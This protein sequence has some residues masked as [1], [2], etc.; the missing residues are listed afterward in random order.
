[1]INCCFRVFDLLLSQ[2][3]CIGDK[4]RRD[5][6]V[7]ATPSLWGRVGVGLLVALLCGCITKYNPTGID[8]IAD[9][10]VVDGVITDDETIITL[11]HSVNLTEAQSVSTYYIDHAMVYVVCDDGTQWEAEPQWEGAKERNGRYLIKNGMLNTGRKYSL[12]IGIGEFDYISDYSYPI[13]TPE[14][15][16][17]FW[18]KTGRGQPVM[19]HVATQ[20][21][22]GN[23]MYCRW[24]YKEDWEI[25]SEIPLIGYPYFCWNTGN[26][27]EMLLGSSEKTVFGRITDVVAEIL[28]SNRKLAVMYRI[29]VRQN[30]IS[31]RG[32]DYYENI[33]INAKQIGS[34]FAPI[35][36]ELRGNITCTTDP[37]RPVI[38]YVDVSSTTQSRMYIPRSANV[39]ERRFSTD[40]EPFVLETKPDDDT[41]AVEFEGGYLW[42]DCVDCTRFG[43]EQKPDD[44][45]DND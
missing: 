25:N 34:I 31:K 38:G 40:C 29:D 2:I 30:A 26:S 22:D 13:I 23:A 7:P 11:S 32:Y 37:G 27:R 4:S 18:M 43:T 33:R 21:T 5:F 12:R 24:R 3:V 36:S 14:I 39:Y 6:T 9:I 8:E 35:P 41:Y 28:P 17:V 16:S 15:D 44:W 10:L 19:I 45:P 20:S 42:R 1:M